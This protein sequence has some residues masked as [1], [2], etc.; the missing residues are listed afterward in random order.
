DSTVA[1]A[2]EPNHTNICDCF[3]CPSRRIVSM[4]TSRGARMY[5]GEDGRSKHRGLRTTIR[6][7]AW[8]S[9]RKAIGERKNE[10]IFG[11][12]A[13]GRAKKTTRRPQPARRV[14]PGRG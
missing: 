8:R 6:L 14:L 4:C 11:V 13:Y 9:L 12:E 7:D 3:M 5:A 1:R 10:S 2:I